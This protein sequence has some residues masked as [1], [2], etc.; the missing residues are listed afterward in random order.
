MTICSAFKSSY[1]IYVMIHVKLGKVK[2]HGF[3]STCYSPNTRFIGVLSFHFPGDLRH[4]FSTL[5]VR[6]SWLIQRNLL[7]QSWFPD[8]HG[9]GCNVLYI[10]P[11]QPVTHLRRT[12]CTVVNHIV[13]LP[14][15][16]LMTPNKS[17]TH[18]DCLEFCSWGVGDLWH[19]ATLIAAKCWQMMFVSSFQSSRL[20]R[21]PGIRI[22]IP[23][24]AWVEWCRD[25]QGEMGQQQEPQCCK[26]ALWIEPSSNTIWTFGL[27]HSSNLFFLSG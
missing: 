2:I 10:D 6:D 17:F 13:S 8:L 9:T 16:C 18:G 21:E 5:L 27:H 26:S 12:G 15:T 4:W 20:L 7:S 14:M 25:Q 3:L 19:R 1:T 24:L 23:Y 11:Y 22:Q